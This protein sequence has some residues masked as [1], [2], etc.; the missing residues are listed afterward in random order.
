M[1]GRRSIGRCGRC[2]KVARLTRHH[3]VPR[4]EGGS[5]DEANIELVCRPCHDKIHRMAART[6]P[7]KVSK[8]ERKARKM[9]IKSFRAQLQFECTPKYQKCVNCEVIC[10]NFVLELLVIFFQWLD[11]VTRKAIMA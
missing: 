8:V 10:L 3:I 7:R 11:E 9:R 6:R 2:N 5:D 1:N 4:S